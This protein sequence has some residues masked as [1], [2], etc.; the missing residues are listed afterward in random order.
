MIRLIQGTEYIFALT[1]SLALFS[2]VV[3]VFGFV[4]IKDLK[5]MNIFRIFFF[6]NLIFSVSQVALL[7]A[8]LFG[9]FDFEFFIGLN[10][11][12]SFMLALLLMVTVINAEK[13]SKEILAGREKNEF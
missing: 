2:Q 6:A 3:F 5:I 11:F 7:M 4:R 9:N 10:A 1:S 8:A 13:F 12:F